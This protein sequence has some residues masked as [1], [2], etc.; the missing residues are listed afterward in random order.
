M[1]KIGYGY[2]S[3]WH[4]LRFLGY[5]RK[6]FS[7]KILSITGGNRIDWM[8]HNFSK[9][10]RLFGLDRELIGL[11]FIKDEKILE[12][13]RSY[14]PQSGKSQ[15]W[16]AIGKIFFDDHEEWLLVE[17]KGHIDELK[18]KCGAKKPESKQKIQAA[19]EK[20]IRNVGN[21]SAQVEKWLEPYYQ[22]ANRLATINFL[23][24]ECNPKVPA[25]LLFIYFYGDK[26][27]NYD[28]PQNREEWL[29]SINNIYSHLE[30]NKEANTYTNI[31][32]FF[33]PT[34]PSVD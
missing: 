1:G 30:I 26:R 32:N 17:A 20:T 6:Y 23:L 33:L 13:W 15:H 16:D 12:Q 34:H 11:E 10:L 14:W 21:S 25:R 2:G 24:N 5:H 9:E 27:E 28:C 31:H 22:Y 7:K 4:L 18:S 8:D 3:E 19:L 29:P